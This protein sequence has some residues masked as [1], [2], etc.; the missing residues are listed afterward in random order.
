MSGQIFSTEELVGRW[1]DQRDCKNIL[2]RYINAVMLNRDLAAFDC[3]WSKEREDISLG[4]NDGFYRGQAAVKAFY[5]RLFERDRLV[6]QLLQEQLPD[7]LAEKSEQDLY[8]TGEMRF[9]PSSSCVI[10]VAEDA[11]TAKGIWTLLGSSDRVMPE[12]PASYWTWGYYCVDFI[13][14]GVDWKIWHMMYLWDINHLSGQNWAKPERPL[15][16]LEGFE[17]LADCKFPEMT[18]QVCMREPYHAMR[19]FTRTPRVPEP[20]RTFSETFSYGEKEGACYV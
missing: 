15:P 8:G 2:G 5:D 13:R 7:E 1:E 6:G 19:R 9:L 3:F 4:L 20:Y 16:V 18:E 10:E 14:E 11:Q 12:G 17:A